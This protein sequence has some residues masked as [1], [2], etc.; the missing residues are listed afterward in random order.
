MAAL[1]EKAHIPAHHDGTFAGL[2]AYEQAG[3]V[4]GFLLLPIA[5][6]ASSV[7]S[8]NEWVAGKTGGNVV[9]FGALHPDCE[10]VAG[11]VAYI[12]ALGL[13]GIKLHPE[14]QAFDVDEERIM[15]LYETVF[16]QGLPICFHAGAD[17]GFPPPLRGDAQRI[18]K[19]SQRFPEGKIIAAHMGG[20]YQYE[21][22][23]ECLAGRRNVW[24]DTSFATERMQAEEITHL[25]RLHGADRF[26]FGTDAPWARLEAA[27]D[28]VIGAGLT[29]TELRMVFW[30]NAA[31]L[32]GL[33]SSIQSSTTWLTIEP[34]AKNPAG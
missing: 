23:C 32:L 7:R 27:Q 4:A 28:A 12:Q 6:K 21:T 2:A 14:Y 19:V 8:I 15:P 3:G 9:A 10:D 11:E 24:M 17:L 16:G 31:K 29:E 33:E 1:A 13:K 5:T 26:L 18:A 34:E 30:D 25:V 22:V 20:L